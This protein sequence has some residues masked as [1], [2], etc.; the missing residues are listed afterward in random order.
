MNP[1][2]RACT[3]TAK[4]RSSAHSTYFGAAKLTA[5]PTTS[6]QS[7]PIPLSLVFVH[8]PRSLTTTL[9]RP[10]IKAPSML[11]SL[12]SAVRSSC[13]LTTQMHACHATPC[14]ARHDTQTARIPTVTQDTFELALALALTIN[15]RSISSHFTRRQHLTACCCVSAV[16]RLT[17]L[18]VSTTS[19][20][21]LHAHF[22]PTLHYPIS[23]AYPLLCTRCHLQ[24]QLAFLCSM[25]ALALRPPLLLAAHYAVRRP[26]TCNTVQRAR[27]RTKRTCAS[28]RTRCR[29]ADTRAV[30][31]RSSKHGYN[32]EVLEMS[33]EGTSDEVRGLSRSRIISILYLTDH[34]ATPSCSQLSMM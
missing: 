21:L 16:T 20:L 2:T 9:S 12:P 26:T 23:L 33:L 8:V 31:G 30:N 18:C 6:S 4:P 34:F 3:R 24:P 13:L 29:R 25:T 19:L 11:P 32:L 22:S 1:P 7:P 14:G 5:R 15:A 28:P 27:R 17:L 10:G